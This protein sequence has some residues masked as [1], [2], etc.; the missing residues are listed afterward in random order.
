MILTLEAIGFDGWHSFGF[1]NHNSPRVFY[2]I[3]IGAQLVL[4]FT[5]LQRFDKRSSDFPSYYSIARIWQ[6]GGDPYDL[7]SQCAEMIRVSGGCAPMAHP[8]VMLPILSLVSSSDF[9][10]S[11]WR[12]IFCTAS[13]LHCRILC[14]LETVW[15]CAG[16]GSVSIILSSDHVDLLRQ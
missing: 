8:P 13:C 16:I 10:R 11:Y 2:L 5:Y 6:R 14:S 1:M 3:I 12:W 15:Q 7:D 9:T 4:Y